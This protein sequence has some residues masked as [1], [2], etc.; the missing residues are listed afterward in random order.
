MVKTGKTIK[1]KVGNAKAKLDGV[2]GPSP[3]PMTNLILT[4]LLLRGG[5]QF[6][7]HAVEGALLKTKYEPGKAKKI[8]GGRTMTQTLISTAIARIATRSVPG[9]I[10]V[11]GGMLAK[12]LYDRNQ[13]NRAAR[14]EGEK[15]VAA[16]AAK[17]PKV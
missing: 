4:D 6:M 3:N 11:G 12:M 2:E 9:A 14:L 8:I 7:R 17:A 5:G 15:A 13:N 1:A 10:L 16:Q